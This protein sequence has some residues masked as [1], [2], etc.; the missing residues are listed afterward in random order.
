MLP[1]EEIWKK[2]RP[3]F[4]LVGIVCGVGALFLAIPTPTNTQAA[5]ALL[6]IQFIWLLFIGLAVI[7]LL[8]NMIVFVSEMQNKIEQK[9]RGKFFIWGSPTVFIG[10]LIVSFCVSLWNYAVAIYPRPLHEFLYLAASVATGAC[11]FAGEYF[12]GKYAPMSK[13]TPSA[14]VHAVLFGTLGYPTVFLFYGHFRS[15]K[16]LLQTLTFG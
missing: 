5:N 8:I 10:A 4:E 6:Q 11:L 14:L 12:L 1:F 13:G 9:L 2:K 7:A 3:L 15:V 16:L